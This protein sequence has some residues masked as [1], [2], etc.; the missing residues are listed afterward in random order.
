ME[1][2]TDTKS[3]ITPFDKANQ[4]LSYKIPF[5]NTATTIIY[6]FS[7][8]TCKSLYAMLVKICTRGGNPLLLS[9]LLK[10]ITHCLTVSTSTVWSPYTL[11]KR[12][13][14]SVGAIFSTWSYSVTCLCF[15]HT[16]TS[17]IILSDCPSTAACHMA[18]KCNGI[19]VRRSPILVMT[20]LANIMK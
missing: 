5:L 9:L 4:I 3:T 11:K 17:D 14:M 20:S 10:D 7:S 18:M 16:F 6:A 15:I 12:Q 13:R 2:T 8:S 19:L 1:T